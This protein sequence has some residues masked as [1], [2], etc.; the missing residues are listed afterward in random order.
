M[1]KTFLTF[2]FICT[3]CGLIMADITLIQPAGGQTLTRGTTYQIRWSAPA[4]EASQVVTIFIETPNT[5][6][7]WIVDD[8][9]TKAD[10][11]F[12]WTVGRIKN[13][14]ILPAGQYKISLETLDG[15]AFGQVF[16]IVNPT[17]TIN[18]KWLRAL[19]RQRIRIPHFPPPPH[20]PQ[21]LKLDLRRLRRLLGIPLNRYQLFLVRGNQRIGKLGE[22]GK[23]KRLPGYASIKLGGRA[24][25][26]KLKTLPAVRGQRFKIIIL[27]SRGKTIHSQ[28]VHLFQIR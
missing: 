13:G 16:T 12:D 7:Y 10:G 6:S 22:F 27:T 20:C 25:K 5:S 4:S 2:W 19:I 8:S 1:K 24:A 17:F 21:C 14:T 9:R 23:G 3:A 28:A 26:L 11:F 15:D 18:P